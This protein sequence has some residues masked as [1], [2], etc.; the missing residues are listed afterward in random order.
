MMDFGERKKSSPEQLLCV[1]LE[2]QVVVLAEVGQLGVK[3]F[4]QMGLHLTFLQLVK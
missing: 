2:Y 1:R 4:C 3:T